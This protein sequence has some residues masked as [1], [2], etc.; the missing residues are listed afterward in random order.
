MFG[1][2]GDS[3]WIG[4]TDQGSPNS[5]HWLSGDEVSYTNWNRDQ[6]GES[7]VWTCH[8]FKCRAKTDPLIIS[9]N[10]FWLNEHSNYTH[11]KM[12]PCHMRFLNDKSHF[13][14]LMRGGDEAPHHFFSALPCI[15]SAQPFVFLLSHLRLPRYLFQSTSMM[16]GVFPWRR[17]SQQVC[18]RWGSVRHR[19]RS[20]SAA[21]TRARL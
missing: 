21:R 15:S 8:I 19:R 3:F 6:P 4:L 18:G 20:S 1:R 14:L 13:V 17:A 9:R 11:I 5:F 2:S 12:A 16:R 10:I 7:R